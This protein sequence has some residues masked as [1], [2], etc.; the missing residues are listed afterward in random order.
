MSLWLG[1][2][3]LLPLLVGCGSQ[4]G[5]PAQQKLLYEGLTVRVAVPKGWGFK[6]QWDVQF[7][8]WS[9]RTG[10]KAELVEI[11]MADSAGP[12]LKADD[13]PQ[14]IVFPWSRRGE[15]LATKDLQSLPIDSLVNSQLD[16]DDL[17]QG[18]REKQGT[19]GA[20]PTMVPL[21]APVLVC[22]YRA[23]LLEKAGL[24]PPE[25]WTDYQ[26]LLDQL[27]TWAPGLKAVEPWS[28]EFRATMFFARALPYVKHS[29]HYSTFFDSE[30]GSPFINSPG[31]V[32]ALEESQAA[33]KKLPP[34][35]LQ[36]DPTACRN[37]IISG[38]SALAIGL[39]TGPTSNSLPLGASAPKSSDQ[40]KPIKRADSISIGFCRLPGSTEVFNSTL[41]SWESQK[42]E[43]ANHVTLTGFGG[44]CAAVPTGTDPER[45]LAV[46]NL[47]KSLL[48]DSQGTSPGGCLSLCRETQTQET[49]MWVGKGL[50]ASE[51]G[52]YV[53]TVAKSLRDRQQVGELPVLGHAEFRAALTTGVTSALEKGTPAA[54]VL[55]SVTKDWE[56]IL[57]K[58]GQEKVLASYRSALG[59]TKLERLDEL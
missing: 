15:L 56:E 51:G 24:Q 1:L 55:A 43:A 49:A 32:K 4:A 40:P 26:K 27:G 12:L 13:R 38:E 21:G 20:G 37:S 48:L 2:C 35:V 6:E 22:Y 28:P 11:D 8:D 57:K 50:G 59:L 19:S 18:L 46:L 31:F 5:T 29:G 47:L 30:K 33:L 52:R 23:D 36:Y 54:E 58:F 42:A 14:L 3:L 7:G 34:E 45:S 16:W 53:A 10:A 39:E 44:L 9:A 17:F 41:N 25:T